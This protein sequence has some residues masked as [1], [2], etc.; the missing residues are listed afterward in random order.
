[1]FVAP[2]ED[3]ER[4]FYCMSIL[5]CLPVGMAERPSAATGAVMRPDTL[6]S[7]AREA[8]FCEVEILP[9]EAKSVL[10]TWVFLHTRGSVLLAA[11]LHA[12]TNL[13]VVSPVVSEGA[14]VALLLLA[15]LAKWVLVGAVIAVA[16]PGL[17]QG[18]RPETQVATRSS[19]A[20]KAL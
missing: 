6:R 7:Y 3:I 18:L 10:F 17:A 2:G 19:P 15:A 8:G 13:F 14:G 4:S 5:H 16:G 1:M 20:E 11:L 9:I 12:T